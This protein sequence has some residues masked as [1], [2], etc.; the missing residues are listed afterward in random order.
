MSKKTKFYAIKKG[1]K[2]GIFYSWEECKVNID[3]FS[4]AVYKSFT[5]E[6]EAKKYLEDTTVSDLD[7]NENYFDV[8]AYT[9]GSYDK[10]NSIFFNAGAVIIKDED[11][12]HKISKRYKEPKWSESNNVAG[13]VAAV[14]EVVLFAI[15]N[16]FKKILIYSDYEGIQQWASN[17]WNANKN[18]SKDFKAF[19]DYYKNDIS[20]SFKWIKGHS[21]NKY[22]DIADKLAKEGKT[23][24]STSDLIKREYH[25]LNFYE[26]N[27][28]IKESL[29]NFP[30]LML[31]EKDESVTNR[32]IKFIFGDD[33]NHK[34]EYIVSND[35]TYSRYHHLNDSSKSIAFDFKKYIDE[36]YSHDIKRINKIIVI[37]NIPLETS[38]EFIK[39]LE[40]NYNHKTLNGDG[41]KVFD[42]TDNKIVI[43]YFRNSI[44]IQ[45]LFSCLLIQV[46]CDF[47]N[48]GN[49]FI[50]ASEMT[51]IMNQI[52]VDKKITD[53]EIIDLEANV[54]KLKNVHETNK[55]LIIDSL[56]LF[57]NLL[58]NKMSF[59]DYSFILTPLM[60]ATETILIG[61]INNNSTSDKTKKSLML[62]SGK[63]VFSCFKKNEGNNK[64][65]ISD[66]KINILYKEIIENIY[67]E[68]IQKWRHPLLHGNAL[69]DNIKKISNIDEIKIILSETL[70]EILKIG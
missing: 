5:N 29:I 43:K 30:G 68:V 6:E 44:L 61:L 20:I 63:I 16:N 42:K 13:E 57:D 28:Y 12:L 32:N 19:L 59:F 60:K 8:I 35:G 52:I 39:Y 56:K 1:H 55:K 62:G 7:L 66:K 3:G 50:D 31:L 2:I 38:K 54:L 58:N 41:L 36:K 47:L 26:I 23:F 67:N 49:N 24:S 11:I 17:N 10:A 21:D 4:G 45:G 18:V 33:K 48:I 34:F 65:Y 53:K 37:N 64:Y 51:K 9:D 69:P 46:T 70:E 22:N 15:N 27:T 40:D 14:M 25:F